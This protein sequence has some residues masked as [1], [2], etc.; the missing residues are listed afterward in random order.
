[1]I[2]AEISVRTLQLEIASLTTLQTGSADEIP[3]DNFTFG[4]I[5]ALAWVGGNHLS[6][7]AM[8]LLMTR[9]EGVPQ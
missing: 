4:A 5:T 2:K 1:M 8:A 7:A 9:A 6:P 3:W